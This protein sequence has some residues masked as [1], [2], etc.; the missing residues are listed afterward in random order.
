MYLLLWMQYL[1]LPC[2][3]PAAGSRTIR[4]P[5]RPQALRD[6]VNPPA[7]GLRPPVR[8]R[9]VPAP[10]SYPRQAGAGKGCGQPA[11]PCTTGPPRSKYGSRTISARQAGLS[12]ASS[13]TVSRSTRCWNHPLIQRP[14]P[15][16][17]EWRWTT[18]PS[19]PAVER[20]RGVA[21]PPQSTLPAWTTRRLR[22]R[23]APPG[24]CVH[25]R[26]SR[27]LHR[28]HRRRRRPGRPRPRRSPRH[29]RPGRSL[30]PPRSR[31]NPRHSRPRRNRRCPS[32][33]SPAARPSP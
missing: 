25:R 19:P 32:W 20:S 17:F 28:P 6:P 8:L 14:F 30:R 15:V 31:Q 21:V 5:V 4:P 18:W 24:R 16:A 9:H 11:G 10:A 27:R 22:P 3:R 2:T 23:P 33:S 26:T 7:R 29:P 13:S 1:P 12:P